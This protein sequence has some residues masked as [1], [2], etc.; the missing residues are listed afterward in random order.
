MRWIGKHGAAVHQL[1]ICVHH[2]GRG[3]MD[4]E[5]FRGGSVALLSQTPN[6]WE[7]EISSSSQFFALQDDLFAIQYLPKLR[8]LKLGVRCEDSWNEDC[9]EPLKHL[10]ALT[11]LVMSIEGVYRPLLVS[12]KLAVLTQLETLE[13][14]SGGTYGRVYVPKQGRLMQTLSQLTGLTRLA[15]TGMLDN[16]PPQLANL[17]QLELLSIR[18]F[19]HAAPALSIPACLVRCSNLHHIMLDGMSD[20][21]INSWWCICHSLQCLPSLTSLSLYNTDL[22]RVPDTAWTLPSTLTSLVLDHCRL[23]KAPSAVQRLTGLKAFTLIGMPVR[24]LD[25]GNYLQ[26]LQTMAIEV[27]ASRAG[28][29]ALEDA[30]HLQELKVF[31]AHEYHQGRWTASH[32][33]R[34]LPEHCSISFLYSEASLSE[35]NLSDGDIETSSESEVT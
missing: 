3:K 18:R 31:S 4:W 14:Q 16:F 11:S 1:C 12:S 7:L 21:S 13:L 30:K 2:N 19:D 29:A 24:K 32:L 6:L 10:T 33:K 25:R 17:T 22:D 34:I 28:P 8:S 5:H 35:A 23:V 9:L 27:F 26:N 15:L 20:D